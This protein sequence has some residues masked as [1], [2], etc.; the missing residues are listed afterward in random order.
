ML[1]INFSIGLVWQ[2]K[3]KK[4]V[5]CE[6]SKQEPDEKLLFINMALNSAITQQQSL[7][8]RVTT[9]IWSVEMWFDTLFNNFSI[10]S[11]K[12]AYFKCKV[13]AFTSV[14]VSRNFRKV[15]HGSLKAFRRLLVQIQGDSDKKI[16]V[17]QKK[18]LT[19]FSLFQSMFNKTYTGRCEQ[20]HRSAWEDNIIRIYE[21]NLLAE[22]GHYNYTLRDNHISDLS[23]RDYL[24]ELVSLLFL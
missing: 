18:K 20:A 17:F 9:I 24:K 2:K 6:I 23:P 19:N 5:S 10:Q 14:C 3:N 21:H 15:T 22:A 4:W 12:D 8:V 1:K 7:N 13:L 16:S 11:I